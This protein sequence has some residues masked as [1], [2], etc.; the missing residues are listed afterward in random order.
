MCSDRLTAPAFLTSTT[1]G[2]YGYK[3]SAHLEKAET[4]LVVY[5]CRG[6][7]MCND[8]ATEV[9]VSLDRL[10]PWYEKNA[11]L[12]A[13]CWRGTYTPAWGPMCLPGLLTVCMRAAEAIDSGGNFTQANTQRLS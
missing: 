10:A 7:K 12:S 11:E 6:G 2:R 5:S 9:I 3:A 1:A 13:A 8:Y 4:I